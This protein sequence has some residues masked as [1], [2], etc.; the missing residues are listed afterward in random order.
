MRILFLDTKPNNPNRYIATAAFSALKEN[1]R[2]SEA[3]WVEYGDALARARH[4]QFDAFIAFD[5]EE[6]DNFVVH[7]LT[8]LIP[9]AAIWFTEDP[10]ETYRNTKVASSFDLVFSNDRASVAAYGQAGRYLPL[11]GS[12]S[13]FRAV[14]ETD[15]S[16]DIFFA[17]TA[18]PNRLEF[19][20]RLKAA[21]PALK[22]NLALV[23]NPALDDHIAAYR[24]QFV[25]GR[26]LAMKDF[27]S[28]ANRARLTLTLPRAFSTDPDNPKASSDTPGPR[29]FEVALAGST[30]LVDRSIA[31]AAGEFLPSETFLAYDDFPACLDQIDKALADA[32]ML[33]EM[34]RAAQTATMERHLYAHRVATVVDELSR[35][36]PRMQP[37]PRPRPKILIVAHNTIAQGWFGGSEIYAE[38]LLKNLDADVAIMAP[39]G[40]RNTVRS[41]QLWDADEKLIDEINIAHPVTQG[42]IAHD[43]FEQQFQALLYRHGFDIVHFNHIIRYPISVFALAKASGAKITFSLHDYYMICENFTLLGYEQRFCNIPNRPLK[44]CAVCLPHFAELSG[45][46]QAQRLRAMRE[47]G[48]HIDRVFYGSEASWS[49][50]SAMFPHL[51]DRGAL[52]PPPVAIPSRPSRP[53][54]QSKLRVAIF[55]N[56]SRVKGAETL[57]QVFDGA[58]SLDVGFDIFG[59]VDGEYL[60]VLSSLDDVDVVQ[61]GAF[62]PGAPPPAIYD[63]KVA[64]IVSPWPETYC[65]TLSEIQLMGIVPIVTDIGGH[66][67]RVRHGVDGLK[68]SVND[69]QAMISALKTLSEDRHEVERLAEALRARAYD[70]PVAFAAKADGLFAE[71]LQHAPPLEPSATGLRVFRLEEIGIFLNSKRFMPPVFNPSPEAMILTP[72]DE[73]LTPNSVATVTSSPAGWGARINF[74]HTLYLRYRQ[75]T[76]E[77]GVGFASRRA[78]AW[79]RFWFRRRL[80]RG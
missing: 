51:A 23:S 16:H 67:E 73:V 76:R 60:E 80:G 29:F 48:R 21:R 79:A 53:A 4:E 28:A 58:R 64:L 55:G 57:L 30:Q 5:G 14:T 41:Y 74:L 10:Y 25:F 63:C 32:G 70:G 59:R 6:A 34:A 8:R 27:C 11:G 17:G 62:L 61:H 78:L 18:W 15:A 40:E 7:N 71:L 33:A 13:M 69:P 2:V 22:L 1:E 43:E 45:V 65:M 66:A 35:L 36:E 44:T 24:D 52:L 56:F 72:I 68:V 19:L 20:S 37:P 38:H 42:D 54:T 39:V 77:N 47:M 46:N 75:T 3:V 12:P 9:R 49:I 31:A 50:F 26:G